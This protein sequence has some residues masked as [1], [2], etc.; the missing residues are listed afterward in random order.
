MNLQSFRI[1]K[2]FTRVIFFILASTIQ[3]HVKAWEVDLSR[4]QTQLKNLRMPASIVDQPATDEKIV[5]SFLDVSGP[6]QDVVILNTQSG[7]VP[8]KVLLKRGQAYRIHVVNVNGKEKNTSFVL[9]AFSENHAT[10]F[11][12][13]KSFLITPKVDGTFSFACPENAHLG[14]IVVYSDKLDKVP[15]NQAAGSARLPASQK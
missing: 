4:R 12:E 14:Q 5:T 15:Q 13:Q 8:S 6:T 9:D 11:G 10:Y 1:A 7:F 3:V 2:R